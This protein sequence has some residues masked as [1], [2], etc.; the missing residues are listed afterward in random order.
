MLVQPLGK[1]YYLKTVPVNCLVSPF[2][3]STMNRIILMLKEHGSDLINPR[4]VPIFFGIYYNVAIS[5]FGIFVSK[6]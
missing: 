5:D 1:M 2:Y 4:S 3:F 6:L